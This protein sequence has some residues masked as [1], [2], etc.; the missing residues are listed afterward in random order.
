MRRLL[1]LVAIVVLVWA[2]LI[3]CMLLI[4]RVAFEITLGTSETLFM[5]I[6]TQAVRIFVSGVIILVWLYM[7]K[8][9]TD[10]YFWRTVNRS[11]IT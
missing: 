6:V 4:S 9:I 1:P 11:E 7:W 2:M 8:K 10:W 5:R 3:A